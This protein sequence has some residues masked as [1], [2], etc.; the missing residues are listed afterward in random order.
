MDNCRPYDF[1]HNYATTDINRWIGIELAFDDRLVY[2]SKSMGHRSLESTA[3]YSLTPALADVLNELH[4][5]R[6]ADL[7]L[8]KYEV[9]D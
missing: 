9:I 5:D 1:G 3:Y 2:L 4:D 7:Y 6:D 8:K